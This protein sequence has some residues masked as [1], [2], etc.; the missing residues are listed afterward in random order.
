M[1]DDFIAPYSKIYAVALKA[2]RRLYMG[3]LCNLC[4]WKKIILYTKK[5]KYTST[6]AHDF[7]LQ[8]Q[9]YKKRKEVMQL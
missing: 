2:V 8:M 7:Q 9:H 5:I 4:S 3:R 1:K 6:Y